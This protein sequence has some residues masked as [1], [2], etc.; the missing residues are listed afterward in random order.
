MTSP[1]APRRI[2]TPADMLRARPAPSPATTGQ[3]ADTRTRGAKQAARRAV[4]ALVPY[5][6]KRLSVEESLAPGKL[7]RQEHFRRCFL[8]GVRLS[9]MPASS[10]LLAHDLMWRASHSTGRVPLNM[11][12]TREHLAQAT[13]LSL[14]QVDAAMNTLAGRGWLQRRRR[15]E[16]D[17]RRLG[18]E[19]LVLTIPAGALEDVRAW[20]STHRNRG[21]AR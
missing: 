12:P 5:E 4:R 11:Q 14:S 6:P 16:A 21:I 18:S 15:T 9:S 8:F 1:A 7:T 17:G 3:A 20:A 10:R 2:P 13:G 19:Q